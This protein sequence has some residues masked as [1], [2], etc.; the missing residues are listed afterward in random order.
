[1][2]ERRLAAILVADVVGYS[3]LIGSDEAG[4]LA[5]LQVL[6]ANIIEPTIGKHVGR[7]FKAVGDGFLVEFA[8][9]VQ[10]VEAARAIQHANAEGKLPLRIGIHIGDV[11]VQG[12]DL[13]GDGVNIA[14]RIEGV[15]DAGGIAI[16]RAVHEQV[17][18]KLNV[19]FED[20][21]EIALKN[22]AR[23]VHVFALGRGETPTAQRTPTTLVLPDKPSIAV[24]PFQN[25]SGDAEQEHFVD[26]IAEDILTTLSKIR[27]LLVI[28]RN[29]SFAFKGQAR[30]LREIGRRLGARYL[31]EGSVR[32]AGNRV[33]LTAQLID[34]SDGSHRWADRFEGNL[35]DVFELQDRITQEIA[36]A[37]E[38]EL[39][40]G[41]QARVWRKRSG[42][43]LVYEH[44]LKGRNLYPQFSRQ[45][46]AQ[47]RSEL[48]RALSTNPSFAPALYFLG[49]VLTDQTRFGWEPTASYDAALDCAARAFHADPEGW[50]GYLITGYARV[51]QRRHAEA[52]AAGERAV[53]LCPSGTDVH[54]MAGMF[55]G[56][57]GNFR[58]AA[59]YEAL[60]QRLSPLELGVQSIDHARARYHLGEFATARDLARRVLA[61]NP[62][63][64][65]AMT[66]LIAALWRMDDT[67][68][69][70]AI[71]K[72]LL[73]EHPSF[74]VA[75][76]SAMLPYREPQDLNYILEPLRLTGL[77]E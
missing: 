20:K 77:P 45:T 16:S 35:D 65:S 67:A 6:R 17:R 56:Y 39:T 11:V 51:F 19:G 71:A 74:S 28:A 41:E 36:T 34:G 1:V 60:A 69:S 68:T 44:F 76:W 9:A 2:T 29:S 18:D 14:A 25:M 75:R 23:P 57:D 37:L 43:P 21:G 40:M 53:A 50:E 4:T 10:A 27:E 62:R 3:K 24:L 38:V 73:R 32:K 42:S 61:T 30:D 72:D 46:H 5:Q 54:H 13:M 33:R 66:T 63:W 31:V 70:R 47:A 12:G 59:H 26:G 49:Y 55:H 7:L 22:L 52:V 64:L 58:M 48:E 8:S 15:A